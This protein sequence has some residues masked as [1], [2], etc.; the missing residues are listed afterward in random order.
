MLER[1]QKIPRHLSSI[2]IFCLFIGLCVPVCADEPK[3]VPNN[4]AFNLL[5]MVVQTIESL[6]EEQDPRENPIAYSNIMVIMSFFLIFHTVGEF[7]SV[8]RARKELKKLFLEKGIELKELELR[9][10]ED[11]GEEIEAIREDVERWGRI[12]DQ[13]TAD[14]DEILVLH[15]KFG[16]DKI[17]E[18]AIKE[19]KDHGSIEKL[20]AWL[21][22]EN[23]LKLLRG[24]GRWVNLFRKHVAKANEEKREVYKR[25]K[26]FTELLQDQ[27]PTQIEK[28]A[29]R[30]FR[31]GDKSEPGAMRQWDRHAKKHSAVM[32]HQ[33]TVIKRAHEHCR[34][35]TASLASNLSTLSRQKGFFSFWRSPKNTGDFMKSMAIVTGTI[36]GTHKL[37]QMT[38]KKYGKD[39]LGIREEKKDIAELAKQLPS[40]IASDEGRKKLAFFHKIVISQIAAIQSLAAKDL[41]ASGMSQDEIGKSLMHFKNGAAVQGAGELAL[42]FAAQDVL[43]LNSVDQVVNLL[44]SDS[45]GQSALRAEFLQ[46]FYTRL[47]KTL[48]AEGTL[49]GDELPAHWIS[50]GIKKQL[51]ELTQQ[52]LPSTKEKESPVPAAGSDIKEELPPSIPDQTKSIISPEQGTVKIPN[53]KPVTS[54]G[55]KPSK[56]NVGLSALE[57]SQQS[58]FP[59]GNLPM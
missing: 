36:Y 11:F 15:S 44:K 26:T 33:N 2:L 29:L 23:G 47:L 8:R 46:A 43:K 57:P 51:K 52:A 27:L 21:D 34:Q 50:Y 31:E 9:I 58:E 35:A 54:T 40:R 49:D 14:F 59:K 38:V 28:L 42:A 1:F 4:T 30:P 32:P 17:L 56:S 20:E 53:G 19:W 16:K 5:Q 48:T 39:V 37:N 45:P 22:T 3:T 25:F 10:A 24:N 6:I 13:I 7:R 55:S 18:A 12:T 41:N